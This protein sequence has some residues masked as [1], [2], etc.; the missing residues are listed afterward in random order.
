MRLGRYGEEGETVQ[1]IVLSL[2]LALALELRAM[3]V[4]VVVKRLG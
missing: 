3:A 4:A 2:G 1:C